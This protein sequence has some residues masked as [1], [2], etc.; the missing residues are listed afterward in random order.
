MIGQI[1]ENINNPEILEG[2]YQ[3]DRKAFK[4][5]FEKL[6][7]EIENKDMAGFWKARLEFGKTPFKA[8][9]FI[10][11]DFV[12]LLIVCVITAFLIKIPDIFNIRYSDSTFYERN[13]AI[14]VAFGLTL[15]SIL[16]DKTF[17]QKWILIIVLAFLIPLNYINILPTD[18]NSHSINLA[19][20]HLPLLMWYIYGIVFTGFDLKS[21]DKRI[22]FI[23]YNGDMLIMYALIAIAGGLLTAITIGLFEAIDIK[24][25]KFYME[26]IVLAGAVCAPVV[27]A[28]IIRNYPTLTNK[29]APLIAGIFS[30]LVLI[31]LIIFLV[32][33]VVTKKD[34]YNDR[35]FLLIFNIMLIGVMGIIVFSVSETSILKNRKF[36]EVILLILSIIA[37]IIDLI[38]LSAI[39]YRLGDGV[40]PNRLAVL[41]SNIL[42]LGNLAIIMIDLFRINF[43]KKEFRIVEMSVAKFLPVYLVWIL[44]VVF[45]FPLIFGMK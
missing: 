12:I 19:Y 23:K 14:I 30:P 9:I 43:K 20:I 41:M 40:T 4:T 28:F 24:I 34:P 5:A 6:Y 26:N 25:G 37:V 27:A 13:A 39:F 32:T 29:L 2:L 3:D 1:R 31:T 10:L 17:R 15:F 38:A 21:G 42:I 7:P 22:D 33:F 45:G 44:I 36:N 35:Q 8:G 16:I 18:E 11:S